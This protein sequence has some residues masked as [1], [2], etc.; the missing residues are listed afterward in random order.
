MSSFYFFS[1]W[2]D[3]IDVKDVKK[4]WVGRSVCGE[5]RKMKEIV[6]LYFLNIYLVNGFICFVYGGCVCSIS[7]S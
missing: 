5:K 4:D 3:F 1:M 7:E 6:V 2:C